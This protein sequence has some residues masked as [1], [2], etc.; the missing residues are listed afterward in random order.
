MF[1]D[2]D[3][4]I[5][6]LT[7]MSGAGK[8]T[9]CEA[10]S[11][12]GVDI[13]NCDLVARTVVLKGRPAL[14]ELKDYFG[15]EIILP[16][17]TLDRKKIGN[18]IFSDESARLAFNNIIYPFISYEMIMNAVKYIKGGSEYIL[19]DAPTLFESGTDS[20]CD[21][22]VS[23][24]AEREDSIKRIMLRDNLSRDEAENRLSSQHPA[25]FYRGKSD[26]CVV[27]KIGKWKIRLYN[28]LTI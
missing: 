18:L 7:G 2:N 28:C 17:G 14:K 10:F 27:N 8:T 23:V 24:V 26:F 5:I 11:E 13:I 15:N 21:I 12:C 16:D 25:E 1:T 3:V 4:Y 20:F 6:G 9:A 19:L 22:I